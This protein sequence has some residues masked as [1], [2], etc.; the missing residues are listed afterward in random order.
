M[1]DYSKRR[2]TLLEGLDGDAF[3]VFDLDRILPS[4]IDRVSLFYLT[5]YTGEGALLVCRDE[6][7]LLTDSRYLEQA[8]REVPDLPLRHAE[9]DYLAEIAAAVKVKGIRRLAFSS[10]R[11]SH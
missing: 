4:D 6:T 5:G 9:G 8:E 3:L 11:M 10:W 7:V 1:I 2:A